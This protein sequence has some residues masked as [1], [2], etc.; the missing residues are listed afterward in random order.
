VPVVRPA[1][2][3]SGLSS[4]CRADAYA[5][6]IGALQG[7]RSVAHDDRAANSAVMEYLLHPQ[8]G[9][10]HALQ[11]VV[12]YRLD[13]AAAAT[14]WLDE[15]HRYVMLFTGDSLPGVNRRSLGIEPMTCAPNAFQ[16]GE[17]SSHSPRASRSLR[18]GG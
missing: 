1:D 4:L 11:L 7:G 13:A 6:R 8:Q 9:C 3:G 16:S 14:L 10:P 5:P 15:G 17:G 2:P 12:T 18:V